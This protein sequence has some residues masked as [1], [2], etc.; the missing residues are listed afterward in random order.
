MSLQAKLHINDFIIALLWYRFAVSQAANRD[1]SPSSK[2]VVQPIEFAIETRKNDPLIEKMLSGKRGDYL[3]IIFAP[4][5]MDSKSMIVEFYDYYVL[6]CRENFNGVNTQ[7]MTTYYK[8]SFATVV[9]NGVVMDM[10]SWKV[11]DP[12]AN[13]NVAPTVINQ[14]EEKEILESYFEDMQGNRIDDPKIGTDANLVI[15]TENAIGKTI[16]VDISDKKKD[17]VYKGQV[18]ENDILK[19][20][21]IKSNI[22]KEK[23]TIIAQNK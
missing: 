16:D 15:R 22:Q 19:N 4:T 21:V 14:E 23:L 2:P 9:I 11:I 3:K 12:M 17:F 6:E 1:G 20:L 8:I 7:P 18:L 13:A 5:T 10:K